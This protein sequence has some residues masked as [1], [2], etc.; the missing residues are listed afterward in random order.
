MCSLKTI[1]FAFC[2]LP[3]AT[4]AELSRSATQLQIFAT[5]VGQLS[6]QMEYQWMFDGPGSEETE[7]QRAA[8]LELVDAL[9]GA[10]D[11]RTVLNWRISAKRAHFALLTRATFNEDEDDAAW[12][13]RR[14]EARTAECGSL[15]LS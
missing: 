3:V 5:C 13:M 2:T 9:K 12:A 11:G 7:K 1:A 4:A 10:E 15:L 6:A 8:M 14:A